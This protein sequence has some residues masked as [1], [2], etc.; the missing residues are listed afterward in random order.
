MEKKEKGNK[1]EDLKDKEE[2]SKKKLDHYAIIDLLF[3]PSIVDGIVALLYIFCCHTDEEVRKAATEVMCKMSS[4]K[5]MGPKVKIAIAKYLPEIFLDAMK[6]SAETCLRMYENS[7]ENPELIWNDASRDKLSNFV[8][9]M[10]A[11]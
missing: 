6:N 2:N 3:F 11:E 8:K 7:H 9:R 10:A 5:L 1:T 4:D